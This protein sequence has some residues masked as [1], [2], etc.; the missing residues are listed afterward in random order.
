MYR[1]TVYKADVAMAAGAVTL[2]KA[3]DM[4]TEEFLRKGI[5]CIEYKDGK[6]VN[7]ADYVQ[8]ELRTAATRSYLPVSYTHLDVY[9]RQ[10]RART[11]S[12][13]CN[14][15]LQPCDADDFCS[16][17]ERKESNE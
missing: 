11:G 9:K 16:Y 15:K 5:N 1:Q 6:R 12:Y 10:I 14:Y 13:W 3:I 2:P 7:I 4:A 8:M 17:G